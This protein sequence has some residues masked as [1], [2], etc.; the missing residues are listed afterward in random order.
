MNK[1][2][3]R[4]HIKK[5]VEQKPFSVNV[6]LSNILCNTEIGRSSDSQEQRAENLYSD[7]FWLEESESHTY[8][9]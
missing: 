6:M 2:F 7:V 9:M 5:I 8:N 4:C 1:Y 3:L